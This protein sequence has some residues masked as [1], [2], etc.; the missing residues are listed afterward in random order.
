[1]R[2]LLELFTA[3]CPGQAK[4]PQT[5]RGNK[6]AGPATCAARKEDTSLGTIEADHHANGVQHAGY[7]GPVA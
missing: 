4:L 7:R 5:G 2:S 3:T 1:M 6:W